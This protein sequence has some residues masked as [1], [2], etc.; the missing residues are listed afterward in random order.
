MDKFDELRHK[1][2]PIL[3]PYANMIAVFGSYARGDETL[4]SD[5]DILVE[6]KPPEERPSLGWHWFGLEIELGQ[7]LGR[8]VELVT[9]EGLSPYIQPYVEQDKVILY[10]ER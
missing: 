8:E 10:D 2:V 3:K 4:D 1:A 9:I 7:L 6:L 5:I